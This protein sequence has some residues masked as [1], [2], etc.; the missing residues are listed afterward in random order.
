M[1]DTLV[2]PAS[3]SADGVTLFAKNS[4]RHPNEGHH[5]LRLPAADHP[6]GAKVKCTY[7]EVP[8]AAHTS[9]VLLAKPYW[10]WGAEMGVNEHGVAIGNEA[11][12][13]KIP[14]DKT[15]GLIGMDL[16]RLALERARTAREA[17]DVMIA[18]L[19]QYGQGG[20]CA[21]DHGVYYH[22]SF[23][24]ADPADA[25][26][27]QTADRQWA[28][29][30]VRDVC[31]IS[32]GLTIGSEWDLASAD[33]V[34]YA[35]ERRWCKGR[36][37]FHFARCYSD[38]IYT[39]FSA[40]KTRQCR[41]TSLLQAQRGRLTPASL[42]QVLRD[43]GEKAGPDWSPVPGLDTVTVCWHA[44]YGPIRESQSVGSLVSHLAAGRQTHFATATSSPCT[45]VF[46]PLWLGARLPETGPVPGPVY[47]PESLFWRH[48]RLHRATLKDFPSRLGLYRQERD[49]LEK[50]FMD[51]A[52]ERAGKSPSER[53]DFSSRC[54]AEAA[55]AEAGW[56][57]RVAASPAPAQRNVFY[58]LAWRGYDRKAGMPDLP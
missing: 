47:D 3:A 6:V 29:Q 18:L 7:L 53:A 41:T 35:V 15:P 21:A 51:G 14:Y 57:E 52:M 16:L 38:F 9:E 37:D 17:L 30:Q 12:F 43:H 25:W 42:M 24:I 11:V 26:T 33:L 40:S 55:A 2:V 46:K 56:L 20:S 19:E 28:A 39:R 5:L 1:C 10:I 48:E 32:N 34:K 58:D 36:D 31:T 45:G 8:Q 54:F 50:R 13:T 49:D 4:D 22:N 44:G 27:F 23:L